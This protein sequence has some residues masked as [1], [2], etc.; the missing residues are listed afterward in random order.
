M[1]AIVDYYSQRAPEYEE[2]YQREDAVRQGELLELAKNLRATVSARRVLELA[3]GTGYWTRLI[4]EAAESLTGLDA[5]PE[6]LKFARAKVAARSNVQILIGDAYQPDAAVGE[7][8]TGV[9]M[10]WFSHIPRARIDEFLASLHK[11]LGSGATVFMADNTYVPGLGG[12]LTQDDQSPDSYKLRKL[13]EG[14]EH[15]VI[16]NY[17]SEA[18]LRTILEPHAAEL[19]TRFG[20]AYWWTRYS[21]R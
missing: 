5:S 18:E 4:V 7:F 21:V 13:K 1:D 17:Y 11:K 15:R 12:E 14:S 16:K 20:T 6:M 19:T 10:F 8:D 3:C 2:I 9:A